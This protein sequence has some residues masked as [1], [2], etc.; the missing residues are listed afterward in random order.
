MSS[1]SLAHHSSE[2]HPRAE[3]LDLG[4]NRR[5]VTQ[6]GLQG[7]ER[8]DPGALFFDLQQTIRPVDR[9]G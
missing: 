3:D 6:K 9:L 4:R 5:I 8:A 2:D 7:L 1:L